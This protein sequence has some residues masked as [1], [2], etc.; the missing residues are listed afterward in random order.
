MRLAAWLM[1]MVVLWT[2]WVALGWVHYEVAALR[3]EVGACIAQS[4]HLW[5]SHEALRTRLDK[6]ELSRRE[7]I[8]R[9]IRRELQA[10]RAE[11]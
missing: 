10:A 11:N 2:S 8:A 1:L 7:L 3:S 4:E 5:A 6:R 9:E